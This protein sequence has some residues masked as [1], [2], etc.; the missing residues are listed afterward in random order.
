M[1]SFRKA[2]GV[3]SGEFSGVSGE[4]LE[5]RSNAETVAIFVVLPIAGLSY[6][7]TIVVARKDVVIY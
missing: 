3:V 5:G 6:G 4:V 1:A 2:V 7:D